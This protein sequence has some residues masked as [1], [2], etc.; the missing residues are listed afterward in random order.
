MPI[1][2][3]NIATSVKEFSLKILELLKNLPYQQIG[4]VFGI[5]SAVAVFV[6]NYVFKSQDIFSST[7]ISICI[8]LVGLLAGMGVELRRMREGIDSLN[9]SL[10]DEFR[11]QNKVKMFSSTLAAEDSILE[12]LT[13]AN[14]VY[15]TFVGTEEEPQRIYDAY[16]K[17][18]RRSDKTKQ[19]VDIV[20]ISEVFSGRYNN[21]TIRNNKASLKLKVLRHSP[22]I[23]N[24]IIIKKIDKKNKVYRNVYVGWI[25]K[26]QKNRKIFFLN[27]LRLWVCSKA[28]TGH[29]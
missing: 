9:S 29:L 19:W 18:F 10:L 7:L 20:G 6:Y 25:G 23:V 8:V 15:N 12:D 11:S 21:I 26:T 14:F 28:Y 22:P 17:F 1:E 24:F 13:D 3:A 2:L 16:N 5:L 4:S 27:T